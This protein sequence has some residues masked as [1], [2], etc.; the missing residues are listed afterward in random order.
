MKKKLLNTTENRFDTVFYLIIPLLLFFY[1]M[2]KALLMPVTHDEAATFFNYVHNGN[3]FQKLSRESANNHYLNTVL[4]YLSY[5]VFGSGKWALRLFNVLSSLLF[6]Y[7]TV[8]ISKMLTVRLMRYGLLT[9]LFFCFNFID[10]FALSRGYGMSMAFFTAVLYYS[11]KFL[12]GEGNSSLLPATLFLILMLAANLS[13]LIPAISVVMLHVFVVLSRLKSRRNIPVSLLLTGL[14]ILVLSVATFMLLKLKNCGALYL[15]TPGADFLFT[16]KSW[17]ILVTG[18]FSVVKLLFLLFFA[19]L[20]VF[21]T[22]FALYFQRLRYFAS[23]LFVFAFLFWSSLAG[24]IIAVKLFGVNYPEGRVGLYL[25]PLFIFS[26]FFTVDGF[27]EKRWQ[28]AVLLPLMFIPVSS[29]AHINFYYT[30]EYKTEVIPG[31]FYNKVVPVESGVIP[32]IAGYH[33]ETTV[34]GYLNFQNGGKSNLLDWRQFPDTLQDYQLFN[35]ELY[36]GIL[37]LYDEL[38][39]EPVSHISLMKRK[40]SVKKRLLETINIKAQDKFSDKP[41]IGFWNIKKG[42]EN[43]TYFFHLKL[44]LLSNRKPLRAWLVF[45]SMAKNGKSNIYKYIPLDWLK[46]VWDGTKY[47]F[48]QSLFSGKI[49]SGTKEIK[50]Y[51]WNIEKKPVLIKGGELKI[52]EIE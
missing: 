49:P 17:I 8:K 51:L 35:I 18:G 37:K 16:V 25:F 12:K 29:L 44:T 23:P 34:W 10:F 13:T 36:P 31:R 45:Q 6:F 40:R 2:L 32:T 26:L 39:Y 28:P 20:T 1:L 14:E 4:T 22:V 21:H 47:N 7:Y 52:Y 24:I 48:E 15:G 5:L 27:G 9:T 50:L 3:I 30:S 43:K 46:D 19:S 33:M 41:F 11:V 42:F 38:D